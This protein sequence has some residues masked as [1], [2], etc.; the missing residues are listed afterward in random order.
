MIL[1][2]Q[3]DLM[4]NKKADSNQDDDKV[5]DGPNSEF[6]LESSIETKK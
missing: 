1:M 3:S 6:S 5:L 2:A 4:S